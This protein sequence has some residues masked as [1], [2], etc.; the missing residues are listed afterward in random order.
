MVSAGYA[1]DPLTPPEQLQVR[2]MA[3]LA[4]I[5]SCSGEVGCCFMCFSPKLAHNGEYGVRAVIWKLITAV[6]P[7]VP[8]SPH[9]IG[10]PCGALLETVWVKAAGGVAGH[11]T[12]KKKV[13]V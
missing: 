11:E 5:C 13:A 12:P 3:A 1:A 4:G 9:L 2:K 8:P 10:I 7:M 6:V